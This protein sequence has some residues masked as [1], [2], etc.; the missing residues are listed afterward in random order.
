ML[1]FDNNDDNDDEGVVSCMIK[2]EC[3]QETNGLFFFIF[4][5]FFRQVDWGHKHI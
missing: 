1:L 3:L 2:G 4:L 5:L